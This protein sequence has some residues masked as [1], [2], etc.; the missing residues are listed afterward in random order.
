[1]DSTAQVG[2][3]ERL[4]AQPSVPTVP[5]QA[6]LLAEVRARLFGHAASRVRFGR[7]EAIAPLGVGG[8]G[9]VLRGRDPELG[10]EVAIK[11]VR[12]RG[13]GVASPQTRLLREAQALARLAHPNVVAVFDVG[14]YAGPLPWH[15]GGRDQ[16]EG[17]YLVMEL[18]EGE[19]LSQWL[20]RPRALVD[21]LAVFTAAGRGLAAAHAHGLLHRDFKPHNVLV[22]RDGRVRVADFGLTQAR[23]GV[24][25][26][27]SGGDAATLDSASLTDDG[28]VL[29]TPMYMAPEQHA[30]EALDERADQYAFCFALREALWGRPAAADLAALLALKRTAPQLPSRP[31]VPA[32]LAR[33][34][35]RGLQPRASAR[36]PS[37][38]ALL[39]ALESATRPPWWRRPWRWLGL[40]GVAALAVVP[41]LGTA[42]AALC[43]ADDPGWSTVWSADARDAVA[44]A[45]ARDAAAIADT[46]VPA[47]DERMTAMG[48]AWVSAR[49][50]ACVGAASSA[51][52]LCLTHRRAA[53]EALVRLWPDGGAD[54][55]YRA[56]AAIEALGDPLAC[57][58][59]DVTT[60]TVQGDDP[61]VVEIE[62]LL[63]TGHVSAAVTAADTA[64]PRLATLAPAAAAWRGLAIGRAF[65]QQGR[66]ADAD[67]ALSEAWNRAE[68]A[69]DAA[70]A[71]RIAALQV[72][73]AAIHRGALDDAD[74]WARH[75]WTA[76]ARAG[77]PPALR[78]EV[79][80]HLGHLASARGLWRRALEHYQADAQAQAEVQ[81]EQSL[82]YARALDN[83]ANAWTHL[84]EYSRAIEIHERLLALKRPRLG[85]RHPDV[86]V[87]LH[88]LA[89]AQLQRGELEAAERNARAALSLW[90]EALGERHPDV[91]L[92][93]YTLGNILLARGSPDAAI[94]SLQA[95]LALR[96]ELLG[97]EH[98]DTLGAI[99]NLSNALDAAERP[100]EALAAIEPVLRIY[101]RPGTERPDH[102]VLLLDH[103]NLLRR[104]GE[105]VQARSQGERA[106]EQLAIDF[107]P[108]HFALGVAEYGL[109]MTSRSLGELD[110]AEAELTRAQLVLERALGPVHPR[111]V[112]LHAEWERLARARGDEAGAA[113]ARQRA[114]AIAQALA[115]RDRAGETRAVA[116]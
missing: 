70:L 99:I 88:N 67:A 112:D 12:G 85:E 46:L 69:D 89:A 101:E 110:R 45:F 22:G 77:E 10:R 108:E 80:R 44:R 107:G 63:A 13:G 64:L 116:P 36:W 90:R 66:Y 74:R 61:V 20:A 38:D 35:E 37:M 4:L 39:H 78:G 24:P 114:T 19:D 1:M 95:S 29:G 21:I 40:G 8:T 94:E 86:G 92:A 98:S 97:D 41:W 76:F 84:G 71:V 83:V 17:V 79:E 57:A 50:Q 81:G 103:A 9:L 31:G 115:A 49:G 32:A 75:A 54:A 30:G 109:A 47:V 53:A 27:P 104:T 55:A 28:V 111:L 91:A 51:A 72:S 106:R 3:V 93:H 65:D 105:L 68:A 7:Y 25:D 33:A 73:I 100:A 16:T 59:T 23:A 14:R 62:A 6:A 2:W 5:G 58:A 26:T 102:G 96:R 56:L 11:L 87:T 34:I 18:V 60:P 42:E 52:T 48:R 15:G 113:A 43:A 82:A